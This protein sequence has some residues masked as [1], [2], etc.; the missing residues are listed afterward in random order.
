VFVV[1]RKKIHKND[2]FS[3]V[4]ICPRTVSIRQGTMEKGNN[5]RIPA[6]IGSCVAREYET[7]SFVQTSNKI[8]EEPA[9]RRR[10]AAVA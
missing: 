10:V 4:L 7:E 8:Y 1:L 9:R 2:P 5:R 6:P 3:R